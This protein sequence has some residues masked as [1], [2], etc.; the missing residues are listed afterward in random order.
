MAENITAIEDSNTE[1]SFHKV[2]MAEDRIKKAIKVKT[3]KRQKSKPLVKRKVTAADTA[4]QS[5]IDQALSIVNA[6]IDQQSKYNEN[7]FNNPRRN[8]MNFQAP[9]MRK[10]QE[11]DLPNYSVSST[12]AKAAA[13]LAELEMAGKIGSSSLTNF[14][15]RAN[16]RKPKRQSSIWW[17]E[18]IDDMGSSPFNANSTSYQVWR[19]VEAFGADPTGQTDSTEAINNAIS[20]GFRC[21]A[22]C[23]SSS[24]SN[25]IIFF[26]AGTYLISSPIISLYGSQLV[27]DPL[28]PPTILAASFFVGLGVISSDVYVGGTAEF[29]INQNNFL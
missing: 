5:D 4:T 8:A 1:T 11:S 9:T 15:A 13:L 7:L 27:G 21:G 20:D 16:P 19:N 28:N 26:P 14:T 10:R 23:N 2:R 12:I 6:A 18:D 22:G 3:V 17:L 29:Y 25:A 24:V